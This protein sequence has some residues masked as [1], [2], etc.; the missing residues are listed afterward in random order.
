MNEGNKKYKLGLALSGGGAKGFAH[1]GVLR[2]LEECKLVPGIISGTS[3]GA[4]AGVLFADGYP[5]SK[6]QEIFTGRE[7]SEF[8]R[9]HIP[10]DGLFDNDRFHH[11]LNHHLRAKRFEDLKIPLVVVA[12]DL[13]N[14][15]SHEFRSGPI[16]DAVVASC[17]IP[18]IFSPVEIDGVHYVDG[19]LFRN[20]PVSTIRH[21]CERVIGVN[22]SPFIPQKYKH[23]LVG[24]AERSYHYLF[25]AN[26]VED[27]LMCD[28]LVEPE[29]IGGYKAFDLEN[30]A[31]IAGLGYEAAILAFNDVI[32]KQQSAIPGY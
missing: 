31:A 25:R 4:I 28:I 8:A 24:V 23:T 15:C 29:E 16:A 5:A 21:E 26:T 2:L 12:T 32:S 14:G 9:L 10:K 30:V 19:G 7:F 20:F 22:V 1:I 3:A 18:I 13:D 17:S 11:F 27:R 6:I